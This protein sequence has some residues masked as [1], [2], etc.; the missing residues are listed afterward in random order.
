MRQP[1]KDYS[2]S[3]FQQLSELVIH[4]L[5]SFIIFTMFYLIILHFIIPNLNY[6][7][8]YYYLILHIFIFIEHISN[9]LEKLYFC[10]ILDH[11]EEIFT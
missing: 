9:R 1:R 8:N 6:Y 11:S 7:Y 2:C 10:P 5:L 4:H 3:N